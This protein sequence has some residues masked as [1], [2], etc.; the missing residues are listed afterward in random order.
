MFATVV[1]VKDERIKQLWNKNLRKESLT[2]EENEELNNYLNNKNKGKSQCFS[3]GFNEEKFGKRQSQATSIFDPVL[4]EI[5]YNWFCIEKG[6]I[7][8]PFAGGSVRGIIAGETGFSYTGIELS[9]IQVKSNYAQKELISKDKDI[10]WIQGDSNKKLEELENEKYDLIFSCPPYFNL[11]VYSEDP[12]D[13]SNKDYN[14]FL[15]LYESIIKKSLD[16]LKNN[17]FAIFTVGD[18]RD[19]SGFY[20]NFVED[21]VKIFEK[22]GAKKY[23]EIILIKAIGTLPLRVSSQFS[24]G[25]KVGKAHEN[26]LVFFKGNPNNIK[27]VF[28]NLNKY[29]EKQINLDTFE[30]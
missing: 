28:G 24:S 30:L 27:E 8:D 5:C 26:V 11:E 18:V 25:R 16:K 13:L 15:N 23:N 17:R 14:N 6:K 10:I 1:G 22:Y 12:D 21:T 20:V 4:C 29:E 19:K 3:K 9:D 7:L 2:D